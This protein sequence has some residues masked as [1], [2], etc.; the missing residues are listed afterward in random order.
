MLAPTYRLVL[1][2]HDCPSTQRS[3]VAQIASEPR[4]RRNHNNDSELA[5]LFTCAHA[6][7]DNRSADGVEDWPLL[8]AGGSY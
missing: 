4:N 3:V 8:V 6:G 5:T 1:I 2:V 7:I